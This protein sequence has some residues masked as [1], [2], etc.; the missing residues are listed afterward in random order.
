MRGILRPFAPPSPVETLLGATSFSSSELS[1]ELLLSI[2]LDASGI[3]VSDTGGGDGF[4]VGLGEGRG[5]GLAPPLGGF[6]GIERFLLLLGDVGLGFFLGFGGICSSADES[7]S[8]A[9]RERGRDEDAAGDGRTWGGFS[10]SDEVSSKSPDFDLREGAGGGAS[11]AGTGMAGRLG[12]AGCARR[13]S[14]EEESE[15]ESESESSRAAFSSFLCR[16]AKP[17]S[18]LL[19]SSML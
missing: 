8:S 2:C 5:D 18:V 16:A 4:G 9:G 10:S 17:R 3:G 12:R 13:V 1:E 7:L 11:A 14:S 6:R 19:R 15:S